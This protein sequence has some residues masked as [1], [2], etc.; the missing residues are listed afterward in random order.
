MLDSD[1]KAELSAHSLYAEAATHCRSVKESGTRSLFETLMHDEGRAHRLS[2]NPDRSRPKI[3]PE[4]YPNIISEN[5]AKTEVL[6]SIRASSQARLSQ[7]SMVIRHFHA[8]ATSAS[9]RETFSVVCL[10]GWSRRA[11]RPPWLVAKALVLDH[12]DRIV[13]GRG[14]RQRVITQPRPVAEVGRAKML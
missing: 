7:L 4:L 9:A 11:S 10:N 3:G 8:P 2:G 13:D 5:L 6:R 14:L 12:I 1:L